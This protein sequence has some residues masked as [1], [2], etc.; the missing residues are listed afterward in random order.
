[1]I[2][3]REQANEE[4]AQGDGNGYTHN[5]QT[6][7]AEGGV[8]GDGDDD[9][10]HDNDDDNDYEDDDNNNDDGGCGGQD[11]HHRMRKGRGHDDR[12]NATIK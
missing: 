1:M 2:R 10:G 7:H 12:T 4:R 3:Q 11:G 5:N 6:D 8:V 9:D